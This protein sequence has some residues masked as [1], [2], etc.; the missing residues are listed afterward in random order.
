MEETKAPV[1]SRRWQSLLLIVGA[2]AVAAGITAFLF[3]SSGEDAGPDPERAPADAVERLYRALEAQD[4]PASESLIDQEVGA[5]PAALLFPR[6]PFRPND[7][8]RFELVRLKVTPVNLAGTW[9]SVRA[10][11]VFR[12]RGGIE[13]PFEEA[14]YARKAA[15]GRWLVSSQD[16]F[17]AENGGASTATAVPRAGTGPLDPQRPTVGQPAPDF[18]LVDARDPTLVRRLSDFRGRAVVVNWYA[19]WCGPCK[20][21]IPEFQAAF[22]AHAT[23][24]VI[25]GVDLRE[26]ADRATGI[27]DLMKAKYPAVLDSSGK[28]AD[29]YRVGGPGGGL[30]TTFF[31]DKDGILREIK[32]GLVTRESLVQSLARIG[33][34]YTPAR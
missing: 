10:E 18:A 26:T 14:V 12:V 1:R 8:D 9:A 33:I 28:V 29:H 6:T 13:R 20:I 19:S 31:I 3:V 11:G 17:L 2:A 4:Q 24:L 16:R 21:E 34:A 23:E 22:A 25:L 5:G 32:I 30:P 15:D 7:G 27:L